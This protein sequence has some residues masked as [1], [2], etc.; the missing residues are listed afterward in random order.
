VED[1]KNAA[2]LR[3]AVEFQSASAM[4]TLQHA[5]TRGLETV[6]QLEEG[7]TL[8]E[9]VPSRDSRK[10]ILAFEATEGGAG[11]L[12]RLV[13]EPKRLADVAKSALNLMHYHNIDEAV[14]SGDPSKLA[15]DPDAKCVKGCYRCL[16]SY[17]NQPDHEFIDRTDKEAIEILIR[18]ARGEVRPIKA[19]QAGTED[20]SQRIAN[21]RLP[22]PDSKPLQVGEQTFPLVWRDHLAVAITSPLSEAERADIEALGFSVALIDSTVEP[23]ADL[24]SLLG[25]TR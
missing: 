4:P 20:L 23:P 24:L 14:A 19:A 11:V 2:L 1:N 10:A 7:E 17:Y 12:S 3:L 22:E 16:L 8:T 9:P 21:W 15:D 13:A 18:I 6:F 25:V 5:F